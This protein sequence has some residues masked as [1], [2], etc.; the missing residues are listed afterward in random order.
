[1]PV[2]GLPFAVEGALNNLLSTSHVSS[3]KIQGNGRNATIVLKL[4]EN[5]QGVMADQLSNTQVYYKKKPPSH[6]QRDR[7]RAEEFHT[8]RQRQ[9]NKR[10]NIEQDTIHDMD[11]FVDCR[12]N[13]QTDEEGEQLRPMTEKREGVA[14]E[15]SVNFPLTS[16]PTKTAQKEDNRPTILTQQVRE[17]KATYTENPSRPKAD[18]S[19]HIKAR[20][21]PDYIE[22]AER[23]IEERNMNLKEINNRLD[24]ATKRMRYNFKDKERNREFQFIKLTTNPSTGKQEIVAGTDD[25]LFLSEVDDTSK[26]KLIIKN[27]HVMYMCNDEIRLS[28]IRRVGTDIDHSSYQQQINQLNLDL[29]TLNNFMK[30]YLSLYLV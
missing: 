27:P 12:T 20:V 26:K 3:W 28:A 9:A 24:R 30:N 29:Q 16:E 8:E 5:R 18:S 11:I 10:D 17:V 6:V 13:L 21:V 23:H 14:Q 22:E 7:E 4:C 25:Y 19:C 2:D 1:M 15:T